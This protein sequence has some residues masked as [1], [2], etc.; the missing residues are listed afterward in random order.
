MGLSSLFFSLL[1]PCPNPPRGTVSSSCVL[2][3]CNDCHSQGPPLKFSRFFCC[4]FS[5]SFF[6]SFTCQHEMKEK[7]FSHY[8][9]FIFWVARWHQLPDPSLTMQATGGLKPVLCLLLL[10]SFPQLGWNAAAAF[11]N[12][13]FETGRIVVVF[14]PECRQPKPLVHAEI[15]CVALAS[16]FHVR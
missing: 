12:F 11:S 7:Q 1:P 4:F 13:T 2:K 14:D 6:L 10:F 3:S 5:S 9:S 15:K 8:S 16:L